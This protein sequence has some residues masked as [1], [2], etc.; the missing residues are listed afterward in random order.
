MSMAQATPRIRV[1]THLVSSQVNGPGRRFTL[2]LQGCRFRC[3]GCSN[4]E[5][6][7]QDRGEVVT[8]QEILRRIGAPGAVEGVTFT[9]GEPFLQARGLLDLARR[10]RAC[11]LSVLAYTGYRL[12]ELRSGAVEGGQALLE[13]VDIL[14]DGRYVAEER[15]PLLWRGSRNQKVHFLTPWYRHLEESANVGGTA[16]VEL[17]IG[18]DEVTVTGVLGPRF[19]KELR[20]RLEGTEAPGDPKP[21]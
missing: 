2:W 18:A 11:G 15:A 17:R 9:G 19:R 16:Q 8:L 10:V 1:G 20:K 13:H 3:P 14:I 21:S 5:F 6:Q 12:E 4:P 7:P